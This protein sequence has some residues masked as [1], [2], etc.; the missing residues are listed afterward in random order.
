[1]R[2]AGSSTSAFDPGR[3]ALV[4]SVQ[5]AGR[6]LFDRRDTLRAMEETLSGKPDAARTDPARLPSHG[7]A[8]H[9]RG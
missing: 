3:A 4:A 6:R 9:R 5:Q 2:P 7:T 8:I 1:M